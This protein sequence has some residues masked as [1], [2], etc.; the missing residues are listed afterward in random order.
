MTARSELGSVAGKG[1][2]I[3]QTERAEEHVVPRAGAK[4]LWTSSGALDGGTI[5]SDGGRS[6]KCLVDIFFYRTKGKQVLIV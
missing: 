3:H 5:A 4:A 6:D 2:R 1:G